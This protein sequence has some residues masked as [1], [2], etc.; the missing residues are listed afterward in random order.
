INIGAE[1]DS[2]SLNLV[3][4]KEF[5]EPIIDVI[6]DTS[7]IKSVTPK[8]VIFKDRFLIFNNGKKV[9][10]IVF[11]DK[12]KQN[13]YIRISRSP[14]G[15]YILFAKDPVDLSGP[16]WI[17]GTIYNNEGDVIM[18]IP[19]EIP[20]YIS[21]DGIVIAN[22]PTYYGETIPSYWTIYSLQNG[23]I[24]KIYNPFN[25]GDGYSDIE[26]TK[27]GKYIVSVVY[28]FKEKETSIQVFKINNNNIS[29]SW[30]TKLNVKLLQFIPHEF[31]IEDNVGFIDAPMG[32]SNIFFINWIGEKQWESNFGLPPKRPDGYVFTQNGKSVVIN[33]RYKK[34]ISVNISNGKIIWEYKLKENFRIGDNIHSIGKDYIRFIAKNKDNSKLFILNTLNGEIENEISLPDKMSILNIKAL[35]KTIY[36]IGKTGNKLAIYEMGGSNEY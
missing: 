12:K 7:N 15:E 21:D 28:S 4:E 36:I 33:L 35:N 5:S 24:G 18:K 27:S 26:F 11:F 22:A 9:Q 31:G 6:I 17:G 16:D 34:L 13:G 8:V 20:L 2:I 10:T 30:E 1:K 29:N 32:S 23:E 25:S 19:K 14:N 3:W